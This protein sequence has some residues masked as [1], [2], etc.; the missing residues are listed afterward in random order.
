MMNG[1][2]LLPLIPMRSS[3][4]HTSEMI[5]QVLFGE[6]FEILEK[7]EGWVYI[8][9][10]H[11]HYKGWISE[12]QYKT[13]SNRISEFRYSNKVYA[14]IKVN[15]V[16]QPLVLGSVI[17]DASLLNILNIDCSLKFCEM[18]NFRSWFLNISKKYLNS[19]YMWGGR[20]PLGID[21]SGYTQMVYR[22]F[23]ICLPR[24]SHDQS[25]EGT[26]IRFQDSKLGDL[27]FFEKDD[28]VIHVG[29]ILDKNRIIHSSGKVRID[30]LDEQGI[31]NMSEGMYTHKLQSLK[32][33][34]R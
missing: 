11:D 9:L 22:F 21:C 34:F 31:F 32:R 27:A 33:V 3:S 12:G 29:I 1:I 25:K 13:I 28:R 26:E 16:R 24:D 4:S 19:P 10:F 23:D 6:S 30:R 5:N 8:R 14:T 2:C 18:N 17:P 7:R 20:S 15:N